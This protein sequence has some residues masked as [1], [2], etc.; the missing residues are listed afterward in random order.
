MTNVPDWF[1]T[2][3][4]DDV[5]D[6]AYA[7]VSEYDYDHDD[8]RRAARD[9]FHALFIAEPRPWTNLADCDAPAYA[10]RLNELMTSAEFFAVHSLTVGDEEK[11]LQW[12][13]SIIGTFCINSAVGQPDSLVGFGQSNMLGGGDDGERRDSTGADDQPLADTRVGEFS[14]APFTAPQPITQMSDVNVLAELIDVTTTQDL[15]EII[16]ACRTGLQRHTDVTISR[17]VQRSNMLVRTRDLAQVRPEVWQHLANKSSETLLWNQWSRAGL[18]ALPQPANETPPPLIVVVDESGS[19]ELLL[20][21]RNSRRTWAKALVLACVDICAEQHRDLVYVGYSCADQVWAVRL[22][23]GSV[24]DA[25]VADVCAHFF[26]GDTDL[27]A[28]LHH[29]MALLR[30]RSVAEQGCDVVILSDGDCVLDAPG[31][32]TGWHELLHQTGSHCW[33]IR[34]G[35]R[36]DPGSTA[37]LDDLCHATCDLEAF[38]EEATAQRFSSLAIPRLSQPFTKNDVS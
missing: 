17:G 28:P 25:D 33:G 36:D 4:W 5:S 35:E 16:S 6:R 15:D 8:V 23:D 10:R 38:G 1:A 37:V 30:K 21:Q 12:L 26:G 9:V 22:D 3:V 7:V 27:V 19:M 24:T 31:L 14:T 13:P 32:L 29:V 11:V 2:R 34:I 18:P 20:D